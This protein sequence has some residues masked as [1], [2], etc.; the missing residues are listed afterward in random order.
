MMPLE[1]TEKQATIWKDL[2]TG[3]FRNKCSRKTPES[4]KKDRKIAEMLD[5]DEDWPYISRELGTSYR[6]IERVLKEM[7]AGELN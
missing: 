3:A 2:K 5:K 4:V 7:R 1:L 6:R